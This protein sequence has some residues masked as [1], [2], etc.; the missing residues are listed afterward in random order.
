[1]GTHC[2]HRGSIRLLLAAIVV[3]LLVGGCGALADITSRDV[4]A[5]EEGDCFNLDDLPDEVG[6]VPRATCFSPT[7][8]EVTGWVDVSDHEEYPGAAWFNGVLPNWCSR[9]YEEANPYGGEASSMTIGWLYPTE[10]SW[11][12]G[13]REALCYSARP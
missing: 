13:E 12:D 1:M 8:A 11:A 3:G 4:G 2:D 5:L 6:R 10:E 7:A 9:K